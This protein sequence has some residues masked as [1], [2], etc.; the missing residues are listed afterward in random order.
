M[1]KHVG[2]TDV[3]LKEVEG[4]Y[5]ELLMGPEKEQVRVDI[6]DWLLVH[7]AVPTARSA[8][9]LTVPEPQATGAVTATQ[10]PSAEDGANAVTEEAAG[11]TAK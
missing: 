3:T 5:H 7:A 6:R 11:G 1:L 2:S 9:E 10:A 8:E 4:G